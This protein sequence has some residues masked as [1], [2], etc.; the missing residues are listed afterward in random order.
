MFYVCMLPMLSSIKHTMNRTMYVFKF[1]CYI[2]KHEISL[3]S[4]PYTYM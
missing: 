2:T 1:A 4:L 3:T